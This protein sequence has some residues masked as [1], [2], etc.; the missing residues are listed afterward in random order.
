MKQD[1]K[2]ATSK[3]EPQEGT[4]RPPSPPKV[5]SSTSP[6]LS[7][8]EYHDLK[9][10][11]DA[12]ADLDIDDIRML[13]VL[14]ESIDGLGGYLPCADSP[15]W[16][17][18][19]SLPIAL[20]KACA[21]VKLHGSG[22]RTV[23]MS[24]LVLRSVNDAFEQVLQ[25]CRSKFGGQSNPLALALLSAMFRSNLPNEFLQTVL[26]IMT[27]G[28]KKLDDLH[29]I[30]QVVIIDSTQHIHVCLDIPINPP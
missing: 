15:S 11:I 30:C 18:C 25:A 19:N 8:L 27:Q 6:P 4:L 17:A 29:G 21:I 22:I 9:N 5:T 7:P 14:S 13:P 20:N 2:K 10:R 12:L 24:G 16:D 1:K 28:D 23:G 26:T 3:K